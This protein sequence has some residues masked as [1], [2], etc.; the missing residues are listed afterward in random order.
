MS[1]TRHAAGRLWLAAMP[2]LFVFLWSTGFIGAKLGLPYAE[3]FTFLA[4]RFGIVAVLLGA[5]AWSAGAPWPKTPEAVGHLAIAGLLVHGTYLGGVFASIHHGVSA[6]VSALIVGI[7]PLL[8]A[9][10]A[11]PL[12]GERVSVRAWLG[13]ALGLVGV[14][15]VVW[16]RIDVGEG[17][18]LGYALSV[19]ALLG[20]TAGT[21]YQKR[22]CAAMDI[23]S[24]GVVQFV[25]AG[26]AMLAIAF[27][28]ETREVA[29][30][31]EFAVALFWLVFVMSLGAIAL[32]YTLIRQ[33][34]AYR[35]ST[36]FYL[37]PP[38]TALI[39]YALF[40]ETLGPLA[41]L[42]M[43]VAAIGVALVNASGSK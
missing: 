41:L 34:E 17:T 2:G 13:L 8:T 33:G 22:F 43:A 3:P 38:S 29:W 37:V 23:R 14:L 9:L 31:P 10:L 35:V 42:G 36:L 4:L 27:A 1:P 28:V 15:L 7:Q 5:I 11:G 40:G 16:T 25:A 6:G 30:T 12:L 26:A 20:M 21:L 39:A 19:A 32:L 18:P 24:G